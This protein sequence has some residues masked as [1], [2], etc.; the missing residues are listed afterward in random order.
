LFS[1]FA[2]VGCARR[3]FLCSRYVSSQGHIF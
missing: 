1:V 2:D 3:S